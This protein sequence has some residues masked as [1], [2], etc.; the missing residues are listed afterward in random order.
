[1][2]AEPGPVD[3]DAPKEFTTTPSGLKYRIR[4]QSD[5][6]KPR[7]ANNVVAH[8][9]GWLDDGTEFDSSYKRGE[10]T[11]F[12]LNRVIKGWTEG[13]QLVGKGGM[14]ELEIPSDLAYGPMGR[15]PVIP[16]NARLHFLVE[17]ID[18]K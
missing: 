18:I 10:P 5:G 11:P 8:Y 13:L 16:P 4:R 12:P 6:D 9:K 1:M 2:A 17:L 14:I 15:P 3:K 7:A